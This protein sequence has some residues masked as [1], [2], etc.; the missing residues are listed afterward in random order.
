MTASKWSSGSD[1]PFLREGRQQSPV[2]HLRGVNGPAFD[3][4]SAGVPEIT[5]GTEITIEH[6][7]GNGGSQMES[8]TIT[9]VG[10]SPAEMK[11]DLP[12]GNQAFYRIEEKL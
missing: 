8:F 5:A 11:I 9:A 6:N 12:A 4:T 10:G 1:F 3:F 7:S 2:T